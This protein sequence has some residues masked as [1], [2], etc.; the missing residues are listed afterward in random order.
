ML[1]EGDTSSTIIIVHFVKLARW[2]F[3][4]QAAVSTGGL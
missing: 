1:L 2:L 4:V 3:R